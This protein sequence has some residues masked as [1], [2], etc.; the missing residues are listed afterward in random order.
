[1][2]RRQLLSPGQPGRDELTRD[3]IARMLAGGLGRA[4]RSDA[5]NARALGGCD[6]TPLPNRLLVPA[7]VLV[8]LV[9]HPAGLTVLFTQRTAHLANHAG[10]VS[11]PG[12]RIEEGD[13]DPVAAA[14]RETEEEIGL[15]PAAVDLVGRL[16]DYV[17]TTGFRITPVVGLLDP[18]LALA[19][20]PFEVAEVFEVPLEF[21]LDP[22]NHQRCSRLV[23]GAER[24]YYAMPF[25]SYYIWGATAGMLRNL[26]EV[27]VARCD[28]T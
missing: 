28:A 27:L 23:E 21:L 16:D 5:A 26:Y 2:E 12:G 3:G 17:T 24:F 22:G 8:P 10:Q 25:G 6:D 14:L 9:R 7:A 11:F 13:A 4:E 19:P 1:M 15:H 20:D 18:P